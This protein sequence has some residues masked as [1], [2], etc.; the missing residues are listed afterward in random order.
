MI[1]SYIV[2]QPFLNVSITFFRGTTGHRKFKL[3]RTVKNAERKSKGT[4]AVGRPPKWCRSD[5]SGKIQ[6]SNDSGKSDATQTWSEKLT[7]TCLALSG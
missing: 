4:R 2:L 5:K 1:N 6:R 3:S 7:L